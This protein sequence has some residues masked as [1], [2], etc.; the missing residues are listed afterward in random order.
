[1]SGTI[2]GRNVVQFV[3]LANGSATTFSLRALSSLI[4]NAQFEK[5]KLVHF[6]Q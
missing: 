2:S 1:M 4:N 6:P 5:W 3:S